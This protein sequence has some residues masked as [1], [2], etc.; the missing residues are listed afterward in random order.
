MRETLEFLVRA[1]VEE[2]DKVRIDV[3]ETSDR[4]F[5]NVVVASDDVGRVIGKQGRTINSLRHVIRAGDARLG[6]RAEVEV[7]G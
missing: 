2:P 6:R 5:Y 1:I 4:V 3:E 7:T